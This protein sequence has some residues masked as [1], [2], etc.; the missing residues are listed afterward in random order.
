MMLISE[1]SSV[2]G[3]RCLDI[4]GLLSLGSFGCWSVAVTLADVLSVVGSEPSSTNLM[5]AIVTPAKDALLFRH[6]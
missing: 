4:L 6:L 3:R 1:P 5:D 2:I